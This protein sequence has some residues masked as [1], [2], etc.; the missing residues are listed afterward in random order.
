VLVADHVVDQ[1]RALI[2][3]AASTGKIFV[4][5]MDEMLRIRTGERGPQAV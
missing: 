4:Y 2:L 5:P 3:E 1:L